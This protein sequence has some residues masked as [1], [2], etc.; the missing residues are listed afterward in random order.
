MEKI[1][2]ERRDG[3][4]PAAIHARYFPIRLETCVTARTAC[5]VLLFGANVKVFLRRIY[6]GPRD[7]K[8][9]F[10][11]FCIIALFLLTHESRILWN[12]ARRSA[13]SSNL[14][15]IVHRIRVIPSTETIHFSASPWTYS[16]WTCT[17]F[18]RNKLSELFQVLLIRF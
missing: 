17:I 11:N 2:E 6:C 1:R 18:H 7:T 8:I 5:C 12:K 16:R 10:H 14:S 3:R 4:V 15:A 13:E 9:H